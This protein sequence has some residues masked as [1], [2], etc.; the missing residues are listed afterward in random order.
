MQFE[1]NRYA[2][3]YIFN[4]N[5]SAYYTTLIHLHYHTYTHTLIYSYSCTLGIKRKTAIKGVMDAITAD[6]FSP[7]NLS[8]RPKG[9]TD[10]RMKRV[11]LK[12]VREDMSHNSD[13]LLQQDDNII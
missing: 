10:L 2:S 13:L 9:W 12:E 7:K 3:K 8:K 4:F 11:M 1:M 5:L 6:N